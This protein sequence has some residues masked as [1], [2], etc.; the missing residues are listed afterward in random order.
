MTPNRKDPYILGLDLDGVCA[1][2]TKGLAKFVERETGIPATSLPEP[3]NYSFVKSGWPFTDI[4]D[5][6]ATHARAVEAG[7]F[8]WVE[9]M[10]GLKDGID[11]LHDAGVH[12]FIVTHRLLRTGA[13]ADIIGDT[14]RWLDVHGIKYDSFCAT[15]LKQI[16]GPHI[17]VDDAPSNVEA[18]RG[19]GTPTIVFDQPYNQDVA[20]PRASTWPELVDMILHHKDTGEI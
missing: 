13:Y 10:D 9:P 7:L 4:D 16:V 8:R 18:I 20:G 2:Y 12:I 5:Y 19:A 14:S 3:H 15:H 1:D 17:Y 11:R 6:L